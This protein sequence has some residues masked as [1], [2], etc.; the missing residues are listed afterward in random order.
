M[1]VSRSARLVEVPRRFF[2]R[3]FGPS[4]SSGHSKLSKLFGAVLSPRVCIRS[5]AK[6]LGNDDKIAD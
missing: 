3:N 4:H 6:L 5:R 1:A 2:R